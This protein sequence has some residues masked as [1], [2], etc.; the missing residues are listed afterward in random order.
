MQRDILR[1][2]GPGRARG[3]EAPLT[4]SEFFHKI[5][6]DNLQQ[7]GKADLAK[8]IPRTVVVNVYSGVVVQG[9]KTPAGGHYA[10]MPNPR[11]HEQFAKKLFGV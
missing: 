7:A 4:R 10:Q 5:M 11:A 8:D 3:S 1:V 9:L 2:F 6:P